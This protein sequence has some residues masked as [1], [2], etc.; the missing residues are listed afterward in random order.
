MHSPRTALASLVALLGAGGCGL[1][2]SAATKEGPPPEA[3]VVATQPPAPTPP[4]PIPTGR[5]VGR[6]LADAAAAAV[7]PVEQGISGILQVVPRLREKS[8]NEVAEA[9]LA[10]KKMGD[11]RA[12][13]RALDAQGLEQWT[14]TDLV[15]LRSY[16]G[17]GLPPFGWRDRSRGRTY[18]TPALAAVLIRAYEALLREQP[19]AR[20][21]LGDL[22]QPG[23]GPLE[24]G[25][26][27][28]WVEGRDA[29]RLL[30][31]AR[32]RGGVAVVLED[33]TAADYPGEVE[34]FPEPAS[35]VLEEH[36]I[37]GWTGDVEHL[38]L[39]VETRRYWSPT[40]PDADDREASVR[41]A[42][43][44]I[45]RGLEVSAR[46]V[47]SYTPE[48]GTLELWRQ[49]F[50]ETSSKRQVV[51]LST[52]KLRR[53]VDPA[54]I[55]EMRF[56]AWRPGKPRSYADEILWTRALPTA[57]ADEARWQ[58]SLM[59]REAGHVT[60]LA[61]EDAD[62]S[63]VTV[64]NLRHFA[65][66]FDAID[67]EQTWAWLGHLE[68]AAQEVGVPIDRILVDPRVKRLMSRKLSRAQ[69]RTRLWNETIRL[70]SGHDGHHHLR[71]APPDEAANLAGMK[72]LRELSRYALTS[73]SGPASS[74]AA[75]NPAPMAE[76]TPTPSR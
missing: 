52:R 11:L 42:S 10:V 8:A 76:S 64:G 39:R 51:T 68:A 59:V 21:S 1:G 74:A 46:K 62:I 16:E 7:P 17:A 20:I 67:V 53:G 60:H 61:G 43:R 47:R 5:L 40:E 66:D 35:P 71:L 41:I 3:P 75:P 65:V 73:T 19:D 33:H 25:N 29:R 27:V 49:H 14:C 56:S 28:S 26:I 50:I 6:A 37:T 70:A 55:V 72:T 24:Y 18:A 44:L 69:K 45:S 4:P 34:R 15:D 54:A 38:R 57:G 63:W 22:A 48:G 23:C 2:P 32:L 13:D 9:W 58:R 30:A 31:R 12:Q 36:R